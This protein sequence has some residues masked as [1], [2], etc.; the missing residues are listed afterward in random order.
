MVDS[1]VLVSIVVPTHNRPD[2]LRRAIESLVNQ[3]YRH[4][5]IVVVDDGS[6]CN[7]A[8]VVDSFNDSRI[9]LLRNKTPCGA[10]HARNIG[11]DQANG[12]Y[13]TF[14]DDDDEFLPQRIDR[15]LTEWDSGYSFVGTGRYRI[16]KFNI[17]RKMLPEKKI[18][19]GDI[20]FKITI[21]NSVFT[22]TERV[23]LLGGFDESLTSSQDY[24]LWVRLIDQYGSA[25]VIQEAL[26]VIHTEHESPRISASSGKVGGHWHFYQK[27]KSRMSKA[28]IKSKIFELYLYKGK[29]LPLWKILYFGA[30]RSKGELIRM[31]IRPRLYRFKAYISQFRHGIC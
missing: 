5:E 19:L 12:I 27:H 16:S 9:K 23:R 31:Y 6:H 3:T 22:K 10:C 15:L 24:D 20:L 4:I 8:E 13:I 11:I 29:C 30:G 18:T 1:N 28:Q 14:L 17:K 26:Y 21:G 7:V 2:M 25:Y